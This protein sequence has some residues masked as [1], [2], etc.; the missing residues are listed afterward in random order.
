MRKN[1]I[2]MKTLALLL[3]TLFAFTSPASAH[4]FEG[5]DEDH[6]YLLHSVEQR[7]VQLIVNDAELCTGVSDGFYS[8]DRRLIV[9]QDGMDEPGVEVEWTLNDLDTI[10]HESHHFL[11][12]CVYGGISVDHTSTVYFN[13]GEKFSEFVTNSGLT[14]NEITTIETAYR[15]LGLNYLGIMMEIEAFAVARSV[16]PRQLADK[17][18]EVCVMER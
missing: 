5:L 2:L 12:D 18:K 9:C 16:P 1:H 10:R 15:R 4:H 11:Q 13:H 14:R 17:I 6:Q 3:T 8:S 7:G